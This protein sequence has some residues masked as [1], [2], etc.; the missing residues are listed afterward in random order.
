MSVYTQTS[1]IGKFDTM[2][3]FQQITADLKSRFALFLDRFPTKTMDT[4]LFDYL[5]VLAGN[6]VFMPFYSGINTNFF[7][8]ELGVSPRF[9][10]NDDNVLFVRYS[11]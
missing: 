2:P 6:D 9:H 1:P 8:Q 10:Y 4:S 11:V 3:F 5:L 7:V